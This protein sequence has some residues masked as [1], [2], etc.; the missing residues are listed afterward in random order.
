MTTKHNFNGIEVEITVSPVVTSFGTVYVAT[1][2]Y[3]EPKHNFVWLPTAAE[4]LAQEIKELAQM[5]A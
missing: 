4:A 2:N 1:N 3:G 5:F